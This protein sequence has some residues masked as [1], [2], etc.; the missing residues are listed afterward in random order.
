MKCEICHE[1]DAKVAVH[2]MVDGTEKELYVCQKCAEA[3]EKAV[4]AFL[5]DDPADGGGVQGLQVDL[6]REMLVRHDRC[7]V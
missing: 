3:G 7:R 4:R 1:N 6:I 2:R 5:F